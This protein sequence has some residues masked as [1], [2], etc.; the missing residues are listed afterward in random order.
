MSRPI[1]EVWQARFTEA[2][3]QLSEEEQERLMKSVTEAVEAVGGKTLIIC[4]A[5]WANERWPFFGVEVY[6]D[7][8]TVQRHQQILSDLNWA[9]YMESRT[10]L[11]TALV[12]PE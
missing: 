8:E 4:S 9:R 1:Y 11:G 12:A 10:S 6:P 3:Y 7:L 2:W 5:A